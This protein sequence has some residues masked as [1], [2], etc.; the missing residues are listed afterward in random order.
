MA[1]RDAE[2]YARSMPVVEDS[3][4]IRA[5]QGQLFDL[6]QDYGLRLR[7]DPFLR[8]IRF[9][10]GASAAGPGVKVW[11]RAWT[12][13]TMTVEYTRVARPGAVAMK[14]IAG[15]KIFR[16]FAGSWRFVAEDDGTTTVI[17][18]YAFATRWP[19][20]AWMIDP[21]IAAMLRRD[22]RQRLAGLRRGAE[23]D[24]LLAALPGAP[25]GC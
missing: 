8:S 7:W 19:A 15:P 20:L 11:V 23:E 21:G 22:V 25:A 17:F 10:D 16:R 2:H 5:P 6:A 14:M 18:R 3:E 9:L 4:R 13:L 24:G 12:G 1:L